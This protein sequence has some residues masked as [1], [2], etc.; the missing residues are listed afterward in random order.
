MNSEWIIQPVVWHGP[1]A[2]I[3]GQFLAETSNARARLQRRMDG[4][5]NPHENIEQRAARLLRSRHPASPCRAG[6]PLYRHR[7]FPWLLRATECDYY[8]PDNLY[9]DNEPWFTEA[10]PL[11]FRL[12]ERL[13]W[14]FTPTQADTLYYLRDA[15]N[16]YC[17]YHISDVHNHLLTTQ[18]GKTLPYF[19]R[20]DAVTPGKLAPL[21]LLNVS[22]LPQFS[23][24]TYLTHGD[25]VYASGSRLP[26]PA[27]ALRQTNHNGYLWVN[28]QICDAKL[29]P[30]RDKNGEP[31]AIKHPENFRMLAPRWGTDGEDLIVQGQMG[32][33]VVKIYHY[34]IKN[35]DL[36]TF[37]RLNQR[38]AKDAKRAY[39]ITGKTIRYHGDFRLLKVYPRGHIFSDTRLPQV[40]SDY[41]AV[42]DRYAYCCG[43]RIKNA[44]GA[45]FRHICDNYYRDDHTVFYQ[46]KPLDVDA[47][48]FIAVPWNDQLFT[49]DDN[50]ALGST[51]SMGQQ[52]KERWGEFFAA[53]PEYRPR[54][55]RRLNH[56]EDEAPASLREIGQGFQAG[57]WLYFHQQ[58][59]D[60]MDVESFRLL[61]PYLCGDRFGLYLIPFH[62]PEKNVPERFSAQ[63]VER[64]RLLDYSQTYFTDGATVWCH[65]IFYH[66]PQAIK[67]ADLASFKSYDY[68][69]A[70]DKTHVYYHGSIKKD[71]SAAQTHFHGIYAY[72][73]RHLFC[74]GKRVKIDF[75]PEEL[76]F[77]HPFFVMIGQ[78]KL[79]C[80]RYTVSARRIHLPTLTFLN[81][82]FARDRN[83]IYYFDDIRTLHP[84]QQADYASFTVLDG[85]R[86][87]DCHRR[88]EWWSLIS[89][90]H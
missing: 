14:L 88:Y 74:H 62:N 60:D 72:D 77:P 69:W 53:H 34:L 19:E 21:P 76:H 44:D 6:E 79:L 81:H 56:V 42:D 32:S 70:R 47:D 55:W 10:L 24:Y 71:L 17:V 65:T 84:L 51:G 61:T 58:R 7:D 83:H 1:Y 90:H 43:L 67:K 13:C 33:K 75:T 78:K 16:V 46:N 64:F 20:L 54:W 35:G 40:N 28:G 30:L 41:F 8:L 82:Y 49:C 22:P 26:Y 12:G 18:P 15:A 57:R 9:S 2:F 11:P 37:Q 68:G 29:Q 36:A 25:D 52:E 50:R 48:S 59:L 85:T 63:P 23:P 39:Y 4:D 38:Y 45:T 80:E 3:G 27:G 87:Q 5:I 66:L 73:Q 89:R 86:A 31:L